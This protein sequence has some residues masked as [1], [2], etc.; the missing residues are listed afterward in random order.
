MLETTALGAWKLAGIL[1]SAAQTLPLDDTDR[2][3]LIRIS[4][5]LSR[6]GDSNESQSLVPIETPT[7]STLHQ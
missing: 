6:A 2:E 5:A 7:D 1:M 4:A 3:L